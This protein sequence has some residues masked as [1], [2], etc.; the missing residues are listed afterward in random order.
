MHV[1]LVSLGIV[2][3]SKSFPLWFSYV[4]AGVIT[5]QGFESKLYIFNI[6]VQGFESKLYIFNLI[7]NYVDEIG[8]P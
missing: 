8:F 5:V 2:L 3:R 7:S 6:T 1:K 4:Y